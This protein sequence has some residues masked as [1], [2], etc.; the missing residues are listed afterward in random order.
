M[1]DR[2]ELLEAA[3][4]SL[5][6]G[7][8]LVGPEGE[9]A[10]WNRAAEAITGYARLELVTQ[11]IPDLLDRLL[12]DGVWRADLHPDAEPG[13]TALV[14]LHHKQGHDLQAISRVFELRNGMGER[15]GA[16]VSFHPT[17]G[18]DALPH[19]EAGDSDG[20][21]V[22]QTQLEER[23]QTDFDDL[24]RGG[25]PFGLLWIT[26]DQAHELRKTHGAMA[27]EGMLEKVAHALRQGLRPAEDIGRWGKDEFLVISHERTAEML[28][29]H[30]QTLAG[31]ARTADFRWWGDRISLTVSMGAAQVE[32]TETL[33]ELLERA[34]AAM[35]ASIHEGGNRTTSAPGGQPCLPS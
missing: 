23:L 31:L 14:H 32:K 22:S 4:D 18:L 9:I 1:A 25:N 27:C 8:A 11:P 19:G 24:A 15:I 7:I 30:A 13:S 2:T 33:A 28:A 34:K 12:P 35:L 26:V 29:A 3:L 6:E 17:E 21:K 16:A 10:F 20:V 5:P